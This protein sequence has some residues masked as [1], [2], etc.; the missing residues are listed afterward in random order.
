MDRGFRRPVQGG[1]VDLKFQGST[2]IKNVLPV[3]VP[4]LGFAGMKVA[5]GTVAW[6]ARKRLVN[7]LTGKEKDDLR[8]SM[9]EYC[10]LDTLALVLIFEFMEDE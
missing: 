7:M 3:L 9:L 8:K 1:Y 2:A 6:E 10:K 4:E 5:S